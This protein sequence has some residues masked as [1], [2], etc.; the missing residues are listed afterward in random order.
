MNGAEEIPAEVVVMGPIPREE[1]P[2]VE[3]GA[4]TG[5][6]CAIL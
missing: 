4:P 1:I 2:T 3:G 5:V 6:T